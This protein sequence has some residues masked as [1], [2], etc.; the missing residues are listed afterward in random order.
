PPPRTVVR[1]PPRSRSA[2]P[3]YRRRRAA[4]RRR[5]ACVLVHA[6]LDRLVTTGPP[7][8]QLPEWEYLVECHQA[9]PVQLQQCQETGHHLQGGAAVAT[10]GPE[11]GGAYPQQPFPQGGRVLPHTDPFGVHIDRKST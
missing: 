5:H 2:S 11:T 6:Q 3:I 1:P 4:G 7:D 10:Q 9:L 8:G